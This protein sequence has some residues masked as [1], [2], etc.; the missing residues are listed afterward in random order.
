MI[1]VEAL[2]LDVNRPEAELLVME[3]QERTK[4]KKSKKKKKSGTGKAKKPPRPRRPIRVGTPAP[5]A[6][7]KVG[8]EFFG[9]DAIMDLVCE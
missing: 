5:Q 9:I 3:Q 7:Q 8:H 1:P 6:A 4:K 2:G